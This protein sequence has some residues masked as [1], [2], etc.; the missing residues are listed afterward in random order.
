MFSG[1]CIRRLCGTGGQARIRVAHDW[2][3]DLGPESA[4]GAMMA[5]DTSV[6]LQVGAGGILIKR[7]CL[8]EGDEMTLADRL[9]AAFDGNF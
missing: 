5:G 2:C 4:R 9:A 8:Q 7:H 1:V 3:A 6:R